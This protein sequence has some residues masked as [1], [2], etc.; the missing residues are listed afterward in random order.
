MPMNDIARRHR[1]VFRI[2]L[3]DTETYTDPK[4]GKEKQ[5]ARKLTD[6]MRVTS[7]NRMVVDAFVAVFGGETTQWEAEWQ[8]YLPT[9]E[10]PVVILPGQSVSQWWEL[11]RKSVCERRC[12]GDTETLSGKAC[13]CPRDLTDRVADKNACNPMTRLSILCPDVEVAGAGS[14]VTHSMIAAETLPQAVAVAEAALSQGIPVPAVLRVVEHVGK[15]K[16]YIVPQLEIVGVSYNQLTTGEVTRPALDQQPEPRAIEPARAVQVRS[17]PRDT[18]RV[19]DTPPLDDDEPRATPR[20]R[21]DDHEFIGLWNRLPSD[22]QGLLRKDLQKAD[23]PVNPTRMTA[24]QLHPAIVLARQWVALTALNDAGY[25]NEKDRHQ[26]VRDATAGAIES[27]KSLSRTEFDDIV[28]FCKAK[29]GLAEAV[30]AS[31]PTLDGA[32]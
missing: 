18:D 6:S 23:L 5:R 32:A 8:A 27:T 31:Q 10:M 19:V 2:R 12:D 28:E 29:A 7:P 13:M 26:A 21:G 20:G 22:K 3:G 24:E 9:T 30:A 1:D 14:L 25:T 15:A 11:Y 17:E 4:D 16:R